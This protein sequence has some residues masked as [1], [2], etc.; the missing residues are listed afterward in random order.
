LL[1]RLGG[2]LSAGLIL[3]TLALISYSVVM[4]YFFSAPLEWTEEM[5]GYWVVALASL[6]LSDAMVR[7]RH[8]AIDLVTQQLPSG[9]Q[10]VVAVFST[11]ATLVV[12]VIWAWASWETATFNR[13]F[14]LYSTGELDMP[15]WITQVP[16]VIGSGLLALASLSVLFKL[17]A[18]VKK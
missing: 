16:L 6:G 5:V 18:E 7:R 15:I 8:I 17:L 4:R 12:G 10:T 3:A 1:P 14:G 11:L 2:W 13:G 9:A